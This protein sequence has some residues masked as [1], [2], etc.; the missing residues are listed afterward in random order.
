MSI[1]I[2]DT[3]KLDNEKNYLVMSKIEVNDNTYIYLAENNFNSIKFCVLENE[4][5]LLEIENAQLIEQL[6][7]LF[8]SEMKKHCSPEELE[9]INSFMNNKE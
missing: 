1:D 4:D 8:V 7:P 6:F 3:V 5:E 2:K 9:L